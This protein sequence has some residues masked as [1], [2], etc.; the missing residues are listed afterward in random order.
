[1]SAPLEVDVAV[2]GGGPA[3]VAAAIEAARADVA[4]ALAEPARLGGPRSMLAWRV[5]ERTVDRAVARGEALRDA[6]WPEVRAE[7]A[8]LGAKWEERLELRLAD[9]GVDV[10]RGA[11]RLAGPN[12][13]AVEGGPAIR[14]D[15]AVIACGATPAT[16]AGDAP[17]GRALVTPAELPSIERLPPE[18]TVI[19][20]GAAGAELVDALSRVDD[21]TVTWIMDELGILPR[22]ER[23]LAE[24][25]GDVVMGRGVK[26]V[27]GKAVAKL[28]VDPEHGALAELE[29]GRTYSAPLAVLAIGR[30]PARFDLAPAGHDAHAPVDERCRTPVAHL[31]A[32]GEHTGRV[33]SSSAAEAMGRVAGRAAAGMEPEPFDP[34]AIPMVVRGHP[35]LA[36]VGLT[37]EQAGGRR[38]LFRTLRTE[39]TIA[40]LLAGVAETDREKGFLRLVCDSESGVIL[41]ASAAG[42]GAAA[43]V[44]AAAIARRLGGDGQLA[45]GRPRGRPGRDRRA[46]ARRALTRHGQQNWSYEG[47]VSHRTSASRLWPVRSK[48]SA[49]SRSCTASC[50][51]RRSASR[52]SAWASSTRSRSISARTRASS[53]WGACRAPRARSSAILALTR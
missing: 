35:Q 26:L 18:V 23:E 39:E 45:R 41:G 53:V 8:R 43:A 40:G 34:A 44:S 31:F 19:G 1:M 52:P 30:R 46:A 2:V 4:V 3:G 20:G 50:A 11:A 6:I 17:D 48:M 13:L 29:G 16:V 21:V 24:A 36:Q 38:V 15:R 32:A 12:E 14:F 22:F 9:A 42:P 28:K 5:I 33:S 7:T 27:H 51:R 49:R 25:F 37:P 10:V 47:V